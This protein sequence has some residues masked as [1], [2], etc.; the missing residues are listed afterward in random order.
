M[1]LVLLKNAGDSI[2]AAKIMTAKIR[3]IPYLLKMLASS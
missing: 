2:E 3:K 1:R